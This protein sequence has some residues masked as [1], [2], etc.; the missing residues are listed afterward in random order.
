[1]TGVDF[2]TPD[3]SGIRDYIHVCDVAATHLQALD[4]LAAQRG[5]VALNVGRG[6]GVSVYEMI[7]G[8]ERAS[9]RSFAVEVAPRR[10][11]DVTA[12]YG[13]TTESQRVLGPMQYRSLDE[14]C[15]DAWRWE[16]KHAGSRVR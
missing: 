13:D 16:S 9:G 12:L 6:E 5:F 8:V 3:G 7:A 4:V 14:I 15:E 1:V 11:G 10:P 2:D